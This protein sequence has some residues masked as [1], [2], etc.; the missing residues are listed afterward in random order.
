[1]TAENSGHPESLAF[2]SS[3]MVL[4]HPQWM[5]VERLSDLDRNGNAS[6]WPATAGK[7]AGEG[8]SSRGETS[9][10]EHERG[11]RGSE[12]RKEFLLSATL[13]LYRRRETGTGGK[14]MATLTTA[15]AG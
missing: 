2:T 7:V 10:A 1:M 3:S 4:L 12:V 8:E 9:N 5:K 6:W 13:G 15:P 14:P 11:Q